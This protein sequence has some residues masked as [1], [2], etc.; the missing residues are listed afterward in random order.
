MGLFWMTFLRLLMPRCPSGCKDGFKM[1]HN[2]GSSIQ[3]TT[4]HEGTQSLC[5][6]S[7]ALVSCCG[8]S[9]AMALCF[10]G[11]IDGLL[12]KAISIA[13]YLG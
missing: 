6:N 4:D 3:T 7:D 8:R 5:H 11:A 1:A 13:D 9:E 12:T 10:T 2:A